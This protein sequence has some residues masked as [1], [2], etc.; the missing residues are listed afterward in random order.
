MDRLNE[1][2]TAM[3]TGY[4]IT[5]QATKFPIDYACGAEEAA[6]RLARH[7]DQYPDAV[8]EST[9]LYSARSRAETLASFPL[10]RITRRFYDAM[11]EVLPPQYV[12]GVAG[13]FLSEAATQTIHAQFIEHR[14]RTYGGFADL[15]RDSRMVWTIGD[16]AALENRT[17]EEIP[18]LDW[19]PPD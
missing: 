18:A 5:S 11:L 2:G 16:I 19:F 6:M 15:A 8:I 12:R 7:R 9:E 13:F 17:G 1:E 4:Y 3:S 14:G 10:S